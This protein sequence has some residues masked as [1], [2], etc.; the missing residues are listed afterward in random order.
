MKILYNICVKCVKEL[1]YYEWKYVIKSCKKHPN[2]Y[3]VVDTIGPKNLQNVIRTTRGITVSSS[4][5]KT[6][7]EILG[8]IR[9]LN[10]KPLA[11]HYGNIEGQPTIDVYIGECFSNAEC[12]RHQYN[13][14]AELKEIITKAYEAVK[15]K[16]GSMVM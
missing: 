1:H 16:N 4:V 13:T 8:S 15:G 7:G 6:T 10:N 11:F 14:I 2:Y 12:K 3:K 5:D 9:R